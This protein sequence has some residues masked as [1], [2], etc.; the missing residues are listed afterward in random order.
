MVIVGY[1]A[2]LLDLRTSWTYEYGLRTELICMYGTSSIAVDP[3][4]ENV[5]CLRAEITKLVV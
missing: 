2:N 4:W 5:V 3:F 1:L